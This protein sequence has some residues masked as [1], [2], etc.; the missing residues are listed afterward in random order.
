M[1]E[2]DGVHGSRCLEPI[3]GTIEQSLKCTDLERYTGTLS[4]ALNLFNKG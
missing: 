4:L 1:E 3:A 2:T